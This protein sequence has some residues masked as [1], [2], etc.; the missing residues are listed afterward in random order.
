MYCDGLRLRVLS[1]FCDHDGF[2]GVMIGAPDSE[3]HFEFT[4]CHTQ[5]VIPSPTPED[6][7]VLYYPSKSDWELACED[8]ERA[9]FQSVPAFNPYWQER[10]RTYRDPDGYRV[11]LQQSS[12][13]SNA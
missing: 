5:T 10:G 1:R 2:D 3:Y 7:L 9:G 4:H 8:M 6:L 13:S 12:W 11:V